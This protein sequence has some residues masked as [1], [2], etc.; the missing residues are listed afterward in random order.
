LSH[1]SS[2]FS[3]SDNGATYSNSFSGTLSSTQTL[4]GSIRFQTIEPFTGLGN[5]NPSSGEL[6]AIGAKPDGGSTNSSLYMI[7][8][9]N[10]NVTLKIDADGDELYEASHVVNWDQLSL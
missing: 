1:F 8:Q 9:N 5:D 6:E 2:T 7:V 4:G 3:T 10:T